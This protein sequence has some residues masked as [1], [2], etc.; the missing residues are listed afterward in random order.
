MG[1]LPDVGDDIL[2]Q[3]ML[4]IALPCWFEQGGKLVIHAASVAKNGVAI[5]FVGTSGMG[6]ST[7]LSEMI[8]QGWSLVSDDVL[9]VDKKDD[10]FFAIPAYPFMRLGQERICS[11]CI[12]EFVIMNTVDGSNKS[13]VHIGEDGWGRFQSEQLPLKYMFTLNR[14]PIE[15][16]GTIKITLLNPKDALI[17]LMRQLFFVRTARSAGHEL[18]HLTQL[19]ELCQYVPVKE[20]HYSSDLTKLSELV[21]KIEKDLYN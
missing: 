17:A 18:A 12:P 19:S 3:R 5:G 10:D 21:A 2:A 15:E 1:A 4:S 11:L 13:I 20:L 16:P 9:V 7:L 8:N 14:K 6:K